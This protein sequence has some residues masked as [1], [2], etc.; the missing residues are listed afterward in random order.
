MDGIV[1]I[2]ADLGML[3]TFAVV[4]WRAIDIFKKLFYKLPWKWV[5]KIPGEVWVGLSIA[6]GI[7][8]AILLKVNAVDSLIQNSGVVVD[9]IKGYIATGFLIGTSSNVVQEVVKPIGKKLKTEPVVVPSTP[10]IPPEEYIPPVVTEPFVPPVLTQ[11]EDAE[12]F[13][14]I[15]YGFNEDIYVYVNEQLYRVEKQ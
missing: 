12:V 4:L 6:L 3:S 8:A 7:I 9:G 11:V 2:G 15:L 5:Q 1:T 14:K 10:V 13:A